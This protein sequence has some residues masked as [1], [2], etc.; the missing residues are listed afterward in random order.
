M[1]VFLKKY[2]IIFTLL[3]SVVVLGNEAQNRE[4]EI[5]LLKLKIQLEELRAYPKTRNA[6]LA[7]LW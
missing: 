3:I 6:L 5:E 7:G 4:R 1:K 2:V